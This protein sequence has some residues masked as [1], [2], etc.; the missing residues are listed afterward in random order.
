M[1][2]ALGFLLLACVTFTLGSCYKTTYGVY[3]APVDKGQTYIAKLETRKVFYAS[4]L[5]YST[6]T[7]T[8]AYDTLS[9]YKLDDSTISFRGDTLH[10]K[11]YS[12]DT[13]HGTMNFTLSQW[14]TTANGN[15]NSASFTYYYA[16]DSIAYFYSTKLRPLFNTGYELTMHSL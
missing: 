8:N 12:I 4:T 10:Y 6:S 11:G 2:R 15:I 7:T 1:K 14:A 16:Q 5:D 9:V 3:V 13:V